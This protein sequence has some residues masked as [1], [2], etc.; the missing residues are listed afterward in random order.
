M[1]AVRSL[2]VCPVEE[3]PPGRRKFVSDQSI[4]VFNVSGDYYALSNRCLHRGGPACAG[5]VTGEPQAGREPY[6]VEWTREGEIVQCGWHGWEFEI[7]TGRSIAYPERHLR[8][9][10]VRIVDGMVVVEAGVA[11]GNV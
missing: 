10:P 6:E 5:V 9:Y 3:L 11:R 4:C 8:T 2:V 1:M 7:A